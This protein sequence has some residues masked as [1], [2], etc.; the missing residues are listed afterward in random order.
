MSEI[1]ATKEAVRRFLQDL[2]DKKLIKFPNLE[3]SQI[4][5]ES[6]HRAE[7]DVLSESAITRINLHH[8]KE[9]DK[10]I[11]KNEWTAFNKKIT[12]N[13]MRENSEELKTY[14]KAIIDPE[15][16]DPEVNELGTYLTNIYKA[17][18]Y[19]DDQKKKMNN[20]FF[21]DCRNAISHL[22][23]DISLDSI[24]WRNGKGESITWDNNYLLT[25]M[26]QM[27]ATV[28]VINEKVIE[29]KSKL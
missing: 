10:F 11:L 18:E 17:L 14:L 1:D 13:Q 20:I 23:Y 27:N 5:L 26:L 12:L 15:K 24:T 2:E 21:K 29:I 28:E 6:Q 19:N 8:N 9:K 22:D 4:F 16:I 3:L 25:I 7:I